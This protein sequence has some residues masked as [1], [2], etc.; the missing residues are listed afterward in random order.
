MGVVCAG[1][2]I[3]DTG[4]I[5]G[6]FCLAG[7]CTPK[8]PDGDPC[9]GNN[10]CVSDICVDGVCCDGGCGGGDPSDCESCNALGTE[11]QCLP[12]VGGTECRASAGGCDPAETCDGTATACPVDALEAS[13]FVCRAVAGGCD[14]EE[15]CSGVDT[16]CPADVLEATGVVC[17]AA[18]GVCDVSEMCDGATP[19]CPNDGFMSGLIECRS[20][21]GA[22]DI[23]ENCTGTAAACPAD[24]FLDNTNVCRPAAGLCDVAESC[25]GASAACPAD[26]LVPGSTVCRASAGVCDVDE[27]CDGVGPACPLDGFLASTTQCRA[28]LCSAGTAT[29]AENCTGTTA[30]CPPEM[31]QQCDPFVC[32]GTDCGTTCTLDTDCAIGNYCSAGNCVPKGN[33]GDP[34][35]ATNECLSDICADGVCC[36]SACTGQ[37]EACDVAGLAGTCSPVLGA[38]H[39]TRPACPGDGSACDGTCN[40][41]LTSACFLPGNTTQCRAPSCTG[42]TATLEAFCD[43]AGSCPVLQTQDCSPS[44]CG[45]TQ[46]VGNCLTDA[47]CTAGNFCSAG[48]C[49]PTFPDGDPCASDNQCT[50]TFCTD[51]VCCNADCSGQCEACAEAGTEGQCLAVAGAPRGARAACAGDG[52]ACDGVC[53]GTAPDSCTFPGAGVECRA[54]SC[55]NDIAT[56]A[57]F[58]DGAGTC[59]ATQQQN[60]APGMCAG[61]ICDGGCV[62]NTDCQVSEYCSAGVCVPLE[63]LGTPCSSADQCAS[64]ACVDGV[65]CASSCTGQC[66]A[67]AESGNEGACIP[68]LGAPRGARSSCAADGSACD[69]VCDGMDATQCTFPDAATVCRLPSCTMDVATLQAN[70]QGNGTCPALQQQP[71]VPFTCGPTQCA[72][73]C[74]VTTDCNAGNYCSAGVCVPQLDPGA[75]CGSVE[76]CLSGNCVDNVC[77]DTACGDQCAACDVP[78]SLGTCSPVVGS[79]RGARAACAGVGVCGGACDG[80][81]TVACT[82][83]GS[84][85]SCGTAACNGTLLL[86]APACNGAGPCLPANQVDCA[87][88]LCQSGA[89]TTSC[90]LNSDCATGFECIANLCQPPGGMDGGAAGAAGAGGAVGQ[91]GAAGTAGTAGTAGIAGGAGT[92][93]LPDA[94][95]AGAAGTG[96]SAGTTSTGGTGGVIGDA[97]TDAFIDGVDSGDQGSC[98]CRAPGSRSNAPLGVL[99]LAALGA[100][101]VTRR[102]RAS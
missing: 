71:C 17:R 27:S 29:L 60:C 52:S 79:P 48:V 97:G 49:A 12:L 59:P 6:N 72:G 86:A 7:T 1:G 96:G 50:S 40:G 88:F 11:G 83:P 75:A 3:D 4:C 89:C 41:I 25:G 32:Q 9:S 93:G 101:M 2:C 91:G 20:A 61:A 34:C 14:I 94:G 37:C 38:P 77:C 57:A 44:T 74:T 19:A 64:G 15:T 13:G 76:Q 39:G 26:V 85:T 65:C 70:C 53:D 69:G 8:L 45:P 24:G 63:P 35:T 30:D 82:L 102:R 84:T 95:V 5:A 18:A 42:G 66:E 62:L 81:T 36:N 56:L 90:A 33:P 16:A 43:G 68:V 28:P 99:V 100:V 55:T 47:Q 46:C 67:C 31:M 73:D 23:A 51:G 87:P 54:G 80:V 21:M 92:G 10:F 58:C 78:G 98:G 22:C